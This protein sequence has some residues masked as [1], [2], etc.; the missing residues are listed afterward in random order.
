M[1]LSLTPFGSR[2]NARIT[3]F[4]WIQL[5]FFA[6]AEQQADTTKKSPTDLICYQNYTL[7]N[8]FCYCSWKS[9]EESR[10]ATFILNYGTHEEDVVDYFEVGQET[11]FSA[12][13][14]QMHFQEPI[15]VWVEA[16]EKDNVYSSAKITVHLD[17]AVKLDPPDMETVTIEKHG[18]SVTVHWTR[19]DRF[20]NQN[21]FLSTT[22]EVQYKR[23]KTSSAMV[24]QE[25][26]LYKTSRTPNCTK[27]NFE[28]TK[29]PICKESCTFDLD[30]NKEYYIQIR[31]K[32][33]E[34]V[35][36]EWS[37]LVFIPADIDYNINTSY[38]EGTLEKNGSRTLRLDW[39]R[40][41]E[42]Q[43]D[44]NYDITFT[45][46][47]CPDAKLRTH[48]KDNWFNA[49]ISG[50]SYNVTIVTF[51]QAEKTPPWSFTIDEDLTEI[52]F[53]DITL[54]ESQIIIKLGKN[55]TKDPETYCIVWQYS[56]E[57][58]ISYS[59]ITRAYGSNYISISTDNFHFMQCYRIHI[60]SF[61][62]TQHRTIGTAYYFRPSMNIGPGNLTAVN[63]TSHSVLLQWDNFDLQM[64]QGLLKNWEITITDHNTNISRRET[65]QSTQH[66][67]ENLSLGFNCT[68]EVKGITVYGEYTGNVKYVLNSLRD[69]DTNN[70]WLSFVMIPVCLLI[71]I[72]ICVSKTRLRMYLFPVL[73]DP[74]KSN[75]TLFASNDTSYILC[76][77]YLSDASSENGHTGSLKI[78]TDVPVTNTDMIFKEPD[79]REVAIT[80]EIFDN[81]LFVVAETEM[82]LQFAYKKQVVAVT[83]GNGKEVLIQ[84]I[85]NLKDEDL[86]TETDLKEN[87]ALLGI[88]ENA[89]CI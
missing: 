80:S 19:I 45:L 37:Q 51:N 89:I 79:T 53:E 25:C 72:V 1:M 10:N 43:G 11:F 33:T 58:E 78:E 88:S 54:S 64:C 24:S 57:K 44:I 75:A 16:Y 8:N 28:E 18:R 49:S 17:K 36:S 40:G 6:S 22:K 62:T 84:E 34:S 2:N 20:T 70:K 4:L 85:R 32:Y 73:P 82:D 74:S 67:V 52:C 14:S 42:N 15:N 77:K 61:N 46:L 5:I 27:I 50:A 26:K 59:N 30:G 81:D 56:T 48:T 31:Q 13:S 39:K 66:L 76:P 63:I 3:V 68:F 69:T 71:G 55:E 87:V 60:H 12:D 41:R 7:K 35:W 86:E 21:D 38:K 29:L 9:G 23:N 47:P 83:P 65:S